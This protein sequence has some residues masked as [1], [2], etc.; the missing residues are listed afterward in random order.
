MF[1]L[2]FSSCRHFRVVFFSV[3]MFFFLVSFPNGFPLYSFM[4][5]ICVILSHN[6]KDWYSYIPA[7]FSFWSVKS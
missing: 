4:C 2:P 7:T 1:T 3:D 5:Q 6:T